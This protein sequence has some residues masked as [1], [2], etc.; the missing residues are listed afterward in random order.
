MVT[1]DELNDLRQ[2]GHWEE[3]G[4]QSRL[5]MQENPNSEAALRGIVQSLEKADDKS[6][7]YEAALLRLLDLKSR[8]QETAQ[9]LAELY[10]EQ[11]QNEEALRH[12]Q[13]SLRA[14]VEDRHYNAIDELWT[15]L[16]EIEPGNI[17]FFTSITNMLF[18]H[19]HPQKAALLLEQLLP[20]TEQR[21][22]WEGRLTLYK[23]ILHYMPEHA[24]IR[25]AIVDT[26]KHIHG[27]APLFDRI[28]KH[29]NILE[30]RPLEEALEAMDSLLAFLP[31]RFVRHPDWGV[32]RVKELDIITRRVKI[33]F[34]RKRNHRMGLELAQTALDR[35][36]PD[37]F[38]VLAVV[39]KEG[40]QKLK[41][42]NPVE[43]VKIV[44]KSFGGCL[45]GKLMKEHMVP[46]VL[47]D[48]HWT[49][50][51]SNTNSA[52][53]KDPYISVSSGSNKVYT[54]RKEALS[55]ED[56]MIKRFDIA[57]IPH[58]KVERI[59]E[60]LRTT[61][62][63]DIN[64][65]IIKHFSA[66]LISLINRR[67][68]AG[69]R[70]EMWYTNE[71]LKEYAEG[72]ESAAEGVLEP[73]A[74]DVAK[75]S[76]VVE[77]LRF[78][79]HEHRFAQYVRELHPDEWAGLFKEWLL[80]P[81]LMIR[82][83]LAQA[84]VEGG[85]ESDYYVL[86]EKIT[87]NYREYPHSFI[88]LAENQLTN[89]ANWLDGKVS[90][91]QI[92]ERL[93]LLVDFLTSQAKR[94]EKDE[95]LDLRK[96][97]G[98]AREIIRRNHYALFKANIAEADEGLAQ[99]VYRRAQ[100]NEGLDSRTSSDLT[101]IIR[102]RFPNLMQTVTLEENSIAPDGLLCLRETLDVKKALLKRLVEIELPEVVREIE[103]ARQD[104][105]L[106]ENAEYH[107]ARD[108]QKLLA[109]Q[110]AELQEQLHVAKSFDFDDMDHEA[111]GFG[112]QFTVKPAGA[113]LTEEY[114]LL[115]PWESDPD[116]N[117]L[118]YQ[119]PLARMFV[120]Q[121][122]GETI[123]VELPMHTGVYE[124]I[125]IRPVSN[126]RLQKIIDR[127]RKVEMASI[128]DHSISEDDENE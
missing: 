100:A 128:A 111:I 8:A 102:G 106:R 9:K 12:Y 53:R 101:A 49:T 36:S 113:E 57:K 5:M 95:A 107:A 99:A 15:I 72:I 16:I 92:I 47:A 28:V 110:T 109:S 46:A 6:D 25:Q 50:W 123:E 86:V 4:T 81:E 54:M 91:P 98:D 31:D 75:A 20:S 11:D 10:L 32:G 118:S 126:E 22:D 24:E 56:D 79:S 30:N 71:D 84:L 116:N 39:D 78:K 119:A 51:W 67:K 18:E 96:V 68:G 87:A 61:K 74:S 93:L 1:V 19:K 13:V 115:G 122:A 42:E 63:N 90:G 40:L 14:A 94:R 52:L 121:S 60:Y 85:H 108:K 97:A 77:R 26:Y 69:E 29:T 27:D 35:L 37:D 64:E 112:M 59:Y 7:E 70:V 83:E 114:L 58:V 17:Y 55:E 124:I 80:S 44:L 34:Q 62:R 2:R 76:S 38:R 45:N 21:E 88:W 66:K 33:N 89:S 117:V 104:G 3:L 105:D 103:T 82:D 43:L 127:V 120:G 73:I 23:H 48:R 41:E 65:A 125:S